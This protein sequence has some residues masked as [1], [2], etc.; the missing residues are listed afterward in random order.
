MNI[1]AT[2][3]LFFAW[4]RSI[5]GREK[6]SAAHFQEF[7]QYLGALQQK[8]TIK[9]FDTVFLDTH[10]GDLNGFFLLRAEPAKL[11]ALVATGE[12]QTHIVRASL[13]LEGS[14]TVRGFTGEAVMAR[15]NLWSTQL[16]G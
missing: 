10:G 7:S 12:W 13:H 6:L 5:P 9:S 14:G 16:P 15:M 1:M 8:G 2:N 4:N 3:A 11:D